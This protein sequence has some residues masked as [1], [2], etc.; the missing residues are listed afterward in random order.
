MG[1]LVDYETVILTHLLRR[2]SKERIAMHLLERPPRI[3]GRP[4]VEALDWDAISL[5]DTIERAYRRDCG[6]THVPTSHAE[7]Q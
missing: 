7:A 4:P 1:E 6:A 2:L 5:E 3:L